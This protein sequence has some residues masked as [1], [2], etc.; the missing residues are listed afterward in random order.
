MTRHWLVCAAAFLMMTGVAFAQGISS[1]LST[2]TQS[3]PGG[4]TS[5]AATSSTPPPAAPRSAPANPN[6]TNYGTGGMQA[7]P[8]TSPNIGKG[9]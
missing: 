1:G 9:N 7:L 4:N 3:M 5:G 8:G 2:S 6:I